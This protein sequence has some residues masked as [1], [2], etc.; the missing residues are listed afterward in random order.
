M[1]VLKVS[2]GS[3]FSPCWL[4]GFHNQTNGGVKPLESPVPSAGHNVGKVYLSTQQSGEF[5]L[6]SNVISGE[7]EKHIFMCRP[8]TRKSG[9]PEGYSAF[10]YI[11]WIGARGLWVVTLFRFG[12]FRGEG[13]QV[14]I[15]LKAHYWKLNRTKDISN[16]VFVFLQP[17]TPEGWWRSDKNP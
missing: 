9:D 4:A 10:S 1:V 6:L 13:K 3:A 14:Y 5:I 17:F 7:P 11:P 8:D 2:G 16:H 15:R 12:V